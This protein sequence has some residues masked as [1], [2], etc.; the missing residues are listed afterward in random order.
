MPNVSKEF[1]KIVKR[2]ILENYDLLKT[3]RLRQGYYIVRDKLDELREKGEISQSDF[4]YFADSKSGAYDYYTQGIWTQLERQGHERPE[5]KPVGSLW[6]RHGKYPIE[7]FFMVWEQARGF[8]FTE[9]S[10]EKLEEL[11]RFG[12]MIIEPEKGFP[13]RL[14]REKCKE[15]GR[16]VIAIHDADISGEEIATSLGEKTV[17]TTHLDIAIDDV[18]NLG[19]RWEDV[20]KL[21]LPTQLEV[22][23]HRGKRSKRC[24][25][26]SLTVLKSR[27]GIE[28]PFLEYVIVRMM[29]EG[30]KL[31]PTSMDK[32]ALLRASII[33]ELTDKLKDM[34][35]PSVEEFVKE[36]SF[37]DDA[38][39]VD[40]VGEDIEIEDLNYIIREISSKLVESAEWMY[41]KDYVRQ[42]KQMVS[43]KF[44]ELMG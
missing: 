42:A 37:D 18:I 33:A 24:E 34:I 30:I 4:E 27:H 5:A 2:I 16:P 35:T 1:W 14:I 10:G 8:I 12:W 13:T 7:D 22:K 11:T 17:R 15:D 28:N 21:D 39:R 36:L 19:L 43:K 9:K 31:S 26:E 38:V 40:I 32:K 3:E 29:Q 6:T 23:K 20:E 25:L 44:K 41:E